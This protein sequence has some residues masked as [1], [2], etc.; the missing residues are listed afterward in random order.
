MKQGQVEGMKRHD[1]NRCVGVRVLS[2][3]RLALSASRFHRL[4]QAVEIEVLEVHGESNMPQAWEYEKFRC[5]GYGTYHP[6]S[7]SFNDL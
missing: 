6:P 7:V 3:L 5:T 2:T 1:V 4:V